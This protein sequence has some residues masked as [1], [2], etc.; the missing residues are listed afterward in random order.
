MP[1]ATGSGDYQSTKVKRMVKK[2]GPFKYEPLP[3]GYD[4]VVRLRKETTTL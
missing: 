4:A 1:A 3:K 2:L